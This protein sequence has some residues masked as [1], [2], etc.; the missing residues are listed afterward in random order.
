MKNM[1]ALLMIATGALWFQ[2][3]AAEAEQATHFYIETQRLFVPGGTQLQLNITHDINP[4]F[5][6]FTYGELHHNW[7][8]I[9][10]G[11]IFSPAPWLKIG[12]GLGLEV[13]DNPTP[14]RFGSF[15]WT[16][17]AKKLAVRCRKLRS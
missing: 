1:Q 13:T 7:E 11:P 9:Y 5:G 3:T 10:G 17:N 15:L 16:G 6:L 8:Q 12:T 2:V 14:L 4:T